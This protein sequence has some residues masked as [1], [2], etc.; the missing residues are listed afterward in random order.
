M[1]TWPNRITLTRICLIPFFVTAVL[2]MHGDED[3]PYRYIAFGVFLFMAVTDAVDGLIARARG[4]RSR[5]GRILDPLADKFL[6]TTACV[7]LSLDIWPEP[8]FPN[9]VPVMVISRDLIIVVGAA[10]IFFITGAF[11][12]GPTLIGKITTGVQMAA[13]LLTLLNNLFPELLVYISWWITVVFTCISGLQYI[14]IGSRQ[15]NYVTAKP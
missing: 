15:F 1:L 11:K 8:R 5:L 7:L 13:V 2:Q 3:S 10:V 4:E 14:Y 6:L 9:W 12:P